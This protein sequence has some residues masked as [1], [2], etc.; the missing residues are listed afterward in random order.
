MPVSDAD[1]LHLRAACAYIE[2]GMFNE[3][4]A[5]FERIDGSSR[6]LPEL[7]ASRIPL[8]RVSEKWDLMA[9]VA[10]KLTEW[11]P[12]EPRNFVDWADAVRRTE[13][14]HA[15]H[16]ILMRAADLHPGYPTIQFNLA[17]YEA[18]MGSLDRA[19]A[20][21]KRATE[22]DPMFGMMALDDRDLKSL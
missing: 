12:A 1:E 3:A 22:I 2:L 20:Y 10:K 9:I 16:A 13:S 4:Q 18:Q 15:A 17:R 5:E 8:Y 19:K 7:L 6:V 21:L 14:V 11:N